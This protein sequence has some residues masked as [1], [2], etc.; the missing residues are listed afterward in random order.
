MG[1]GVALGVWQEIL[2]IEQAY[3]LHKPFIQTVVVHCSLV[4]FE[5]VEVDEEED[6]DCIEGDDGGNMSICCCNCC[7]G[8]KDSVVMGKDKWGKDGSNGCIGAV[9]RLFG[10]AREKVDEGVPWG[11]P[12]GDIWTILRGLLGTAILKLLKLIGKDD[13]GEKGKGIGGTNIA[14]THD[15]II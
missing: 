10:K 4:Q 13:N 2:F 9:R 5:I 8:C 12:D 1:E 15:G 6:E 14:C 11:N 3:V 7:C